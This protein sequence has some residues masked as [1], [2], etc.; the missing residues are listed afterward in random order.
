LALAII[1]GL[2]REQMDKTN[3]AI[4]VAHYQPFQPISL[5]KYLVLKLW[6]K[7]GWFFLIIF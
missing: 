7:G 1:I 2:H 6:Q 4:D 3:N 5:N